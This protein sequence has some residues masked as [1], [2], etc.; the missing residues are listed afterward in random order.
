MKAFTLYSSLLVTV[1]SSSAFC[2][3]NPI[4]GFGNGSGHQQSTYNQYYPELPIGFGNAS[5]GAVACFQQ[6]VSI[7]NDMFG[8]GVGSGQHFASFNQNGPQSLSIGFGNGSGYFNNCFQQ[9]ASIG[10]DMFGFG[11]GS[12]STISCFQQLIPGTSG[13]NNLIFGF[14]NQSGAISGC[15]FS[16][17]PLPVHVIR[18]DAQATAKGQARLTWTSAQAHQLQHYLIQRSADLTNWETIG[19]VNAHNTPF[20]S[21]YTYDDSY[22]GKLAYYQLIS[23]DLDGQQTTHGIRQVSFEEQLSSVVYNNPVNNV[24]HVQLPGYGM[25]KVTIQLLNLSGVEVMEYH[26]LGETHQLDLTLLPAGCY[27]MR[28]LNEQMQLIGTYKLIT[29]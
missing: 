17:V 3:N 25:N 27:M 8:F 13:S 7:G 23:V 5:G 9:N 2:Q 26:H 29:Y 19:K 1:L 16:P 18:F 11:S 21:A 28:V 20:T 10:T 4:F 24:L 14:G 12:G 22:A 15:T 6:N